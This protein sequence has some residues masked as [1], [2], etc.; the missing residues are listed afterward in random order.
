MPQAHLTVSIPQTVWIGEL[1]RSHPEARFRIL[2]ALADD[3][4][5]FSL[6][7]ITGKDPGEVAADMRDQ[8][9]VTELEVLQEYEDTMLVQFETT[10]PLLLFPVQD[11]GVPLQMP[12][13]IQSGDA[14]WE[15]TA[16]QDRLSE[17]GDQLDAFG[18]PY[19]VDRVHEHVPPERLLTDRQLRLV[20]QAV[21]QGYYDTPRT[22]S[23][24]E[25][26]E[27]LDLAKSTCSETLHRAEEQIVKQYLADV[28]E[29]IFDSR[30]E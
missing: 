13:T 22:A 17:L 20:R 15:I 19:T 3:E 11:S 8:D 1:S 27:A 21:E 9:P 4:A 16:P 5:G 6:V 7:E 25:L 14:E 12:F 18:I 30:N 26:A 10:E 24:T 2:A 28:K 23:L 29:S